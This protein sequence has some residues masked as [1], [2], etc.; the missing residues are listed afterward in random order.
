[1]HASAEIPPFLRQPRHMPHVCWKRTQ[2]LLT[3]LDEELNAV[4]QD[5]DRPINKIFFDMRQTSYKVCEC[6][7]RGAGAASGACARTQ[8][9]AL[10]L[11]SRGMHVRLIALVAVWGRKGGAPRTPTTQAHKHDA[12][13][14][15][16]PLGA[17]PLL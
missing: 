5:P 10:Q 6:G 11:H 7:G 12:A 9:D 13:T 17:M 14:A 2:A 4:M 1:M 3:R 16:M 15:G 8:L